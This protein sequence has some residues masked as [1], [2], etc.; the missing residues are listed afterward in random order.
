MRKAK[1]SNSFKLTSSKESINAKGLYYDDKDMK[2]KGKKRAGKRVSSL[3]FEDNIDEM[4]ADPPS[5]IQKLVTREQLIEILN[6][7]LDERAAAQKP[8]N[9]SCLKTVGWVGLMTMVFMVI[10]GG[11]TVY[12]HMGFDAKIANL[13]AE[14]KQGT[15]LNDIP[16]NLTTSIETIRIEL[17][18][19][20]QR[21]DSMDSSL[22]KSSF[23]FCLLMPNCCIAHQKN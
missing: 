5:P 14:V 15:M 4:Y 13:T 20:K 1:S 3:A 11:A 17:G 12:L 7:I 6:E 21:V 2:N 8:K 10:S 18:Q 23:Y 9:N 22:G 16:E 19:M